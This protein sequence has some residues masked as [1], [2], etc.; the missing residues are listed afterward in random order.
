MQTGET[1]DC[2]MGKYCWLTWYPKTSE[3]LLIDFR[4][5]IVWSFFKGKA[6]ASEHFLPIYW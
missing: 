2:K 1:I 6:E 3:G 5:W 4:L